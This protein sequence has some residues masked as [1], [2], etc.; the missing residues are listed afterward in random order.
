MYMDLSSFPF[1]KHLFL[2]LCEYYV[3]VF[4][5]VCFFQ[6][7][8]IV[9][10]SWVLMSY[11][12]WIKSHSQ[13][14]MGCS[15]SKSCQC[16]HFSRWEVVKR[17]RGW[18]AQWTLSLFA[19]AWQIKLHCC[20]SNWCPA[21]WYPGVFVSASFDLFFLW[22]HQLLFFKLFCSLE[23]SESTAVMPCI[24]QVHDFEIVALHMLYSPR[25]VHS[26]AGS[27]SPSLKTPS[28]CI[29]LSTQ[30]CPRGTAITEL[31]LM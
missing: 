14:T 17:E 21:S 31:L 1:F 8:L 28:S 19:I 12:T 22:F 5:F 4:L 25:A 7:V 3:I 13:L 24:S 6:N 11:C 26:L 20:H 10:V 9:E 23:D 27:V 29:Q 18:F 2:L 30:Q 15:V 16:L